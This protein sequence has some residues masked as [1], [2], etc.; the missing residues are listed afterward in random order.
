MFCTKIHCCNC[1]TL[2]II[3]SSRLCVWYLLLSH[4]LKFVTLLGNISLLKLIKIFVLQL[5]VEAE[6]RNTLI[7]CLCWII[8]TMALK[9]PPILCECV[10]FILTPP[11]HCPEKDP[12]MTSS[13]ENGKNYIRLLLLEVMKDS[14]MA[15]REKIRAKNE[16][17]DVVNV[18]VSYSLGTERGCW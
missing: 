15:E 1:R 12:V 13:L 3:T 6:T 17:G 16:V 18:D 14:P 10:K 2:F 11:R 7:L 8:T 9:K 5:T 4:S